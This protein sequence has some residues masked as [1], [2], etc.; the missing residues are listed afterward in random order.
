LRMWS[1]VSDGQDGADGF[2]SLPLQVG[3]PF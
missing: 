1:D 2:E 3:E